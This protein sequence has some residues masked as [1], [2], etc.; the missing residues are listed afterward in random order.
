MNCQ[1]VLHCWLFRYMQNTSHTENFQAVHYLAKSQYQMTIQHSSNT[2]C[3]SWMQHYILTMTLFNWRVFVVHWL[4][5]V[6]QSDFIQEDENPLVC[7]HKVDQYGRSW[8]CSSV[9]NLTIWSKNVLCM[10]SQN[11]GHQSH[12]GICRNTFSSKWLGRVRNCCDL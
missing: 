5:N 8:R 2:R 4:T 10:A 11:V 3:F 1:T 9:L 12:Q 7:R 6:V